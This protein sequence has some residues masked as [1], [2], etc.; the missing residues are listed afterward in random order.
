MVVLS[1]DTHKSNHVRSMST[2][3][4]YGSTAVPGS[5]S[6]SGGGVPRS[7]GSGYKLG[8]RKALYEKRKRVSDYSLIFAMFGVVA[9]IVETELSMAHVYDKVCTV[10]SYIL[11]LHQHMGCSAVTEPNLKTRRHVGGIY[12]V[13]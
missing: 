8:R 9:M 11:V 2:R 13:H 1:A 3:S 4:H 12:R 5:S 10:S 7:S 6:G